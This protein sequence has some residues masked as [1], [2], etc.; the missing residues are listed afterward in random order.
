MGRE[1]KQKM[2]RLQKTKKLESDTV[3]NVSYK[4]SLLQECS[5]ICESQKKKDSVPGL[6]NPKKRIFNKVPKMSHQS[7]VSTSKT[8]GK[9]HSN[10]LARSGITQNRIDQIINDIAED[11][12]MDSH[13]KKELWAVVSHLAD[14]NMVAGQKYWVLRDKMCVGLSSLLINCCT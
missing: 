10:R 3:R 13:T 8:D 5:K 11:M 2:S 9:K 1:Q 4:K 12:N 6:R 7:P 14:K